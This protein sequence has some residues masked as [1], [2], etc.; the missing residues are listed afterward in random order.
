MMRPPERH[1]SRPFGASTIHH[2]GGTNGR[3][4]AI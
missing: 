4:P 1:S 2:H 3:T